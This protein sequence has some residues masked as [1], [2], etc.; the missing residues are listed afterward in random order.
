MP[1]DPTHAQVL[2]GL[3][4]IEEKLALRQRPWKIEAGDATP[5][6]RV[7]AGF[8]V[9]HAV[10]AAKF[11]SFASALGFALSAREFL[12]YA[13]AGRMLVE[14]FAMLVY[15]GCDKIAPLLQHGNPV[16][17]SE[18]DAARLSDVLDQFLS[19]NR[20]DWAPMLR[21]QFPASL[22]ASRQPRQQ[23][24][25]LT[26]LKKWS[27][28][29]PAVNELYGLLSEM[30]H[31]NAGSLFLFLHRDGDT[32]VAADPDRASVADAVVAQTAPQLVAILQ[33]VPEVLDQLTHVADAAAWA[34]SAANPRSGI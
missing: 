18:G 25:I 22:V 1:V 31:P 9:L 32:L 12:I 19:G 27:R 24:N 2:A 6:Q 16:G 11:R 7:A 5:V 10:Y 14:H 17:I 28:L 23:V 33:R 26:C 8:G 13:S 30:V 34:A 21:S 20:H 15:Y 4:A 3:M 29:D